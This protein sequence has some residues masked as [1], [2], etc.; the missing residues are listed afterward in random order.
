MIAELQK[1]F[2]SG[3]F[4]MGD[5][6]TLRE[7][8]GS[9]EKTG[10]LTNES[11]LRLTLGSAEMLDLA[12]NVHTSRTTFSVLE[13]NLVLWVREAFPFCEIVEH[14]KQQRQTGKKFS[15]FGFA[16]ALARS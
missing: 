7:M 4:K 6:V 13:N 1:T 15:G 14:Q 10:L 2:K 9:N 5:I 3:A 11:L 16:L 12:L 8:I